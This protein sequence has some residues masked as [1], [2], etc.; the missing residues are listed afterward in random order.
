MSGTIRDNL[1]LALP[2]GL[3]PADTEQRMAE[4][5]HLACA[6]FVLSLSLGLDTPCGES[7]TGLSEGQCQ[8]IAIARA[9][10]HDAP[11]IIFDEGISALDAGTAETIL[12]RLTE[13]LKGR[14][15]LIFITHHSFIAS[16]CDLELGLTRRR[17][18]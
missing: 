6:D 17:E 5:L 11:I 15:T 13:R 7:G 14:K 18:D 9:L 3:S 4:A 8:R 12:K 10:L 16:Y 2:E 1:M